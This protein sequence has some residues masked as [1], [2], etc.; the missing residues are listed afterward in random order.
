MIKEGGHKKV[1][2][3]F[4][5][6]KNAVELQREYEIFTYLKATDQKNVNVERF[7]IP[8]V[9]CYGHWDGFILIAI[10]K[11]DEDLINVGNSNS[12]HFPTSLDALIL[13]RNFVS[14]FFFF[15]KINTNYLL[16]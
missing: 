8:A 5:T 10:T 1:A 15:F 13:I 9:Y 14:F 6:L 7:G 16:L 4:F 11:L 12:K 2:I 3:N